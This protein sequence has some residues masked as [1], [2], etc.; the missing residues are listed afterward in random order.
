MIASLVVRHS[1]SSIII[2]EIRDIFST[3]VPTDT[4]IFKFFLW[5]SQ[6]FHP[7]IVEALWLKE[8]QHVKFYFCSLSCVLNAEV[9]PLSVTFGVKI[10]LKNEIVFF[11]WQFVS[12][13]KVPTLETAFKDESGV[14]NRPWDIVG[15][16]WSTFLGEDSYITSV[17]IF[18]SIVLV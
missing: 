1:L 6:H 8:V 12:K 18:K 9:E 7:F 14:L 17:F 5:I 3:S 15:S 10:I 4:F 11:L 16:V 13:L 2:L